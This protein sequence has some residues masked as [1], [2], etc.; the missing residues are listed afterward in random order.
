MINFS[1]N[2]IS[3][4]PLKKKQWPRIRHG[5]KITNSV[6]RLGTRVPIDALKVVV[7]NVVVY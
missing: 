7:R 5:E 6:A 4:K 3:L 1:V 2:R